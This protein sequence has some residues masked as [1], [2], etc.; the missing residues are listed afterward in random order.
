LE[1]RLLLVRVGRQSKTVLAT[2]MASELGAAALRRLMNT[3]EDTG[4]LN[5]DDGNEMDDAAAD[6][7]MENI[8]ASLN[9][10]LVSGARAPC[11]VYCVVSFTTFIILTVNSYNSPLCCRRMTQTTRTLIAPRRR[12]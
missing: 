8:V 3:G 4:A 6:A 10:F 2:L 12:R 1:C 9:D 7:A 11:N 5:G